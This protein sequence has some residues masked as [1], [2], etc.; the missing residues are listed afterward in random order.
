MMSY[1]SYWTV[2]WEVEVTDEFLAWWR[3]LNQ[4]QQE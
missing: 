4:D 3:E 1:A 2:M